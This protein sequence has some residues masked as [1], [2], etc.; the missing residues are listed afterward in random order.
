MQQ[1]KIVK[2]LSQSKYP[3]ELLN[4]LKNLNFEQ[5]SKKIKQATKHPITRKV[6]FDQ[7]SLPKSYVDIRKGK[8]LNNSGNLEG[9]LAWFVNSLSKFKNEINKFISFEQEFQKESLLGNYGAAKQILEKVNAEICYS[10][11]AIENKFSVHQKL[12]GTESN[13][14]FLNEINKEI[15]TPYSLFFINY[16]SI[17]S[18]SEVSILQ[19]KRLMEQILNLRA[20]N[21]YSEY[22]VFK[23]GYFYVKEY[24]DFANFIYIESLS[25]IIDKYIFLVEILVEL[26]AHEEHN[27]LVKSILLEL[28]NYGIKDT[29][30]DRFNEIHNSTIINDFN[31]EILDLFD[32]YSYGK[33]DESL[34]ASITLLKKYPNC[35]EIYETYVKCLL[36]KKLSFVKSNVSKNIDFILE[37]LF[38]LYDKNEHFQDAKEALLKEYLLFPKINFYKQLLSLVMGL[39]SSELSLSNNILYFISSEFSNPQVIFIKGVNNRLNFTQSL[40]DKHISIRINR[41][42]SKN[43]YAALEKEYIPKHK[44]KI[45]KTR[46]GDLYP[47]YVDTNLLKEINID[48]DLNYHFL[49]QNIIFLHNAYLVTRNLK[50]L[51]KLIVESFF[52]NRFLIERLKTTFLANEIIDSNYDIDGGFSIDVPILFF[53][54]ETNSYFQ[55]AALDTFLNSLSLNKPSELNDEQDLEKL[56]YL[57][58]NICTVEVLNN[59]YL[60]YENDDEVI[61]ERIKILKK[62]AKIEKDRQ[63]VFF[64]EIAQLTQKQSIRKTIKKVNDGKISL[65]FS[66]IKEEKKFGIENSFNRFLKLRGFSH[67]NELLSIDREELLNS[68][69]KDV[70]FD[71]L[72]DAAFINFKLLFFEVTDHF[73]FSEEHG[74]EGDLSTRIRHGVFENQLRAIFKPLHL[75]STKNNEYEYNDIDFW[76]DLCNEKTY[77]EEI[78]FD[79][80]KVFKKFSSEVDDLIFEIKNEYLQVHSNSHNNKIYGLFNYRFPEEYL[81]IMYKDVGASIDNYE[82]FISYAF[83]TLTVWTNNS[84]KRVREF[85]QGVVNSKFQNLLNDLEINIKKV[86]SSGE[87]FSEINQNINIA[88]TQIETELHKISKWFK[89][90]SEFNSGVL[91]L[92]TIINTAFE[93]INFNHSE[94][95]KIKPTLDIPKNAYFD[96]GFYFIDIFKILIDNAI[97]HSKLNSSSLGISL[98]GSIDLLRDKVKTN[99]IYSVLNISF[100]NQISRT[101]E[102]E[103]VSARLDSIV[104]KWSSDLS[105]VNIEGGSGLQKIKRI[106]EYDIKALDS[107]LSYKLVDDRISIELKILNNYIIDGS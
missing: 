16:Y 58:F 1:P 37:N 4:M 71:K 99:Q 47:E 11:W 74:L 17:K 12:G 105:K 72:Q 73:L 61:E 91:D 103:Q 84:L 43:N 34:E 41:D 86:I 88:R 94:I 97:E 2:E 6:L 46:I 95:E 39:T 23:V 78:K 96:R 59:F 38:F 50:E 69:L 10:F 15:K 26:S 64:E 70:G 65:N 44:L 98:K 77:R 82:A 102:V 63:K 76:E 93:S 57:L 55:Y 68:Y 30:L 27:G 56:K 81:W 45:Y 62:L 80:Q 13:W 67:N 49:E 14:S 21:S 5:A 52:K 22:A 87:I 104:E 75:V 28:N 24:K 25:S 18:E 29:R 35:I 66:R 53:I 89:I 48:N 33:Y 32:L 60:I 19:Y 85:L 106:L 8:A 42:I 7:G 92:E 54:V 100:E 9:E 51:T 79:I 101:L 20:V 36:E 31:I 90:T 83:D 3:I 107:K 40:Y